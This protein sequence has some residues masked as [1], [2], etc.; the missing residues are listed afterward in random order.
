MLLSCWCFYCCCCCFFDKKNFS[1]TI[2]LTCEC[3]FHFVCTQS[4]MKHQSVYLLMIQFTQLHFFRYIRHT[5]FF[6][7]AAVTA[8]NGFMLYF[9]IC[10]YLLNFVLYK[11]TKKPILTM[12]A[13]A[14]T[15]TTA[16]KKRGHMNRW[17]HKM[18]RKRFKLHVCNL[19][20]NEMNHF[21]LWHG[22]YSW[23]WPT[24]VESIFY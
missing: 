21:V 22:I 11:M 6:V 14:T 8:W 2:A 17:T 23:T 15:T 3:R 1:I 24:T 13:K 19:I 7:S 4:S 16:Q 12:T 5:V 20:L 10:L 18:E 9:T